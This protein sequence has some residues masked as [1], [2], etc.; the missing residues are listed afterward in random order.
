MGWLWIWLTAAAAVS[1]GA[2]PDSQPAAPRRS[3][4]GAPQAAAI[5]QQLASVRKQAQSASVWMLPWPDAP[6]EAEP[7]IADARAAA[8]PVCEPVAGDVIAP[9]IDTAAK[10]QNIEA[11][12]IRAMIERESAFRPCAVSPKGARGLMQ[13]MPQTA[14]E[15]QVLNP[16]DPGENIQ[17]G[18]KYLKQLLD[19][20]KGDLGQA[21]AAYNAGPGAVDH[22]GGI[23]EIPE[24]RDYVNEILGKLGL[25]GV[26]NPP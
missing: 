1:A 9:L 3:S 20:Y 4:M 8:L 19:R 13:L 26:S 10:Q 7:A 22:A 17:A 18:A 25:K 11:K 5:A 24:T 12:L 23:P 16:F 6:P 21:L 2:P 14:Q 15:L